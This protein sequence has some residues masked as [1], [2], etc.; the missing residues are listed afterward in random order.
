MSHDQY[1]EVWIEGPDGQSMCALI[2]GNMGWLMYL[3]SKGDPGFSSRN[4]DYQGAESANIDY[5]LSNGQRDEYPA[6]WA[7][8]IE[9]ID[10][11]L[12]HFRK[13]GRPPNF[14]FWHND[15]GDGSKVD[16]VPL[17]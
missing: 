5:A 7:L 1:Q 8:P 10:R 4:P 6:S 9:V 13:E 12:E 3:R 11:A 16:Y 2:N 15:S 14:V 17:S